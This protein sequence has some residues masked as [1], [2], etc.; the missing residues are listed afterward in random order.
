MG[1]EAPPSGESVVDKVIKYIFMRVVPGNGPQQAKGTE[2]GCAVRNSA[3]PSRSFVGL[4]PLGA[5]LLGWATGDLQGGAVLDCVGQTRCRTRPAKAG[6]DEFQGS[7]G[8]GKNWEMAL[9]VKGNGGVGV[10][11][12]GLGEAVNEAG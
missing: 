12:P 8:G 11:E 1:V 7:G 9:D 2:D 10:I 4:E 6:G 5:Y 3:A